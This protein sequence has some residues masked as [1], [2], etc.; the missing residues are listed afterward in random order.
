MNKNFFK[1]M[2]YLLA[3]VI[4][5]SAGIATT[6]CDDRIDDE[7]RFTFTGELI[8]D[9]LQNHPEKFSHFVEILNKAKI[10]KKSSGS[11]LKTLSTY[12]SYT[13]FAPTN[14][15]LEKFAEEM[16]IKHK[17]S[18]DIHN[19]DPSYPIINTGITS[20]NIADISDSMA[21]EIAKNHII[22]MGYRTID[23]NEGSF[24]KATMNRRATLITWPKNEDGP[25][26]ALLNNSARIIEQDIQTENGY[27]QV[28]DGVLNPSNNL[29]PELIAAQPSFSLFSSAIKATGLDKLLS[30]YEIDP[31]YDG[32]LKGKD[33]GTAEKGEEPYPEE[34]K[35]K[36][37]VLIESNDL[38]AQND[39][40]TL[41][42]LIEFAEK[43]Y[44]TEAKDSCTNP[45]NALYKFVAYHIIDRQLQ[46][47]SGTGPGGFLMENFDCSNFNSEIN[48]P[49]TFD[50]YDYFETMLPYT[51]I[52]VTKPF[53]NEG[54]LR[55]EIVIN[56]AQNMGTAYVKEEMRPH[57]NVI[58]ER[59]SETT[60][61]PGLENFTQEALNGMIHTIDRILIYN[62]DEMVGNIINERM[63]WDI[64]SLFP[65]LTSNG[66]RWKTSLDGNNL[67]YIPKG[68]SERLVINNNDS[69]VYYL[70]PHQT[71]TGQ[72]P[73]YQG[74]ELLVT[75]QYDFEYRLPHV[76]EGDYEIRF[77][78][79]T[80]INRGICQFYLDKKI[81]GIP[82]D[83][84]KNEENT[85]IMGWFKEKG[86]GIEMSEDEIKAN[87]KAMRNRGYMKG[88]AS[89]HLNSEKESMR[90]S[91]M[92]IRKII[93][94]FRLKQGN[95]WLRFKNVTEN[96][97]GTDQFNQDFLEMVPTRIINDP[98]KPEDQY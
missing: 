25:V 78:F 6:S 41:P 55:Q 45:N 50:R 58:V 5:L 66:E 91:D 8:A 16:Y 36:Y 64:M 74:D 27:V 84:R 26:Y 57:I 85:I 83:M 56:Y 71:W 65:E 34:K 76:P 70:R 23:V 3:G 28:I 24:P 82:V 94:T 10:G 37:T 33:F 44:G 92:S 47:S 63:R 49:T 53:T 68:Y 32:T 69:H 75:G 18:V 7:N 38:F 88:P 98:T 87:D 21:T 48:M 31:E 30:T 97:S 96:S 1:S 73:N 43:W 90:D 67:T 15:A 13:C 86:D 93:G 79:S 4:I 60:Q 29:L 72:Y 12:G 77:G 35:Q 89:I 9:H 42:E 80:S 81:C 2:K 19:T 40:N 39:I 22:E 46:Y 20:S 14:E 61:R 59:A 95:H 51:M 17:E 52:K 54:T 62:E 11:I